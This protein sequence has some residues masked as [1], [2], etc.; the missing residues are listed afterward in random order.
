MSDTYRGFPLPEVI[1][2]DGWHWIMDDR[3]GQFW[4]YEPRVA[5]SNWRNRVDTEIVLDAI[6]MG[7]IERIEGTD[8]L[9][10][11]E[12]GLKIHD[13]FKHLEWHRTH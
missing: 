6:E 13:V 4:G 1:E 7:L 8:E 12:C 5:L 11:D 10:C 2:V 3:F 9:A